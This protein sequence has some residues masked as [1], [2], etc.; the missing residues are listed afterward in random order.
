MMKKKQQQNELIVQII[1]QQRKT[2]QNV[3][4]RTVVWANTSRQQFWSQIT[5]LTAPLLM[6]LF[7]GTFKKTYFKK[8][9]SRK[10]LIQRGMHTSRMDERK[11]QNTDGY[12]CLG[13]YSRKKGLV[14]SP[15]TTA[16]SFPPTNGQRSSLVTLE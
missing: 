7:P 11:N 15:W 1:G 2:V 10:P 12:P 14:Q 4:A 3:W 5:I 16:V 6:S 9:E 8:K 13:R